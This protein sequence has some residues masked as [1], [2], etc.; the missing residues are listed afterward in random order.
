MLTVEI[1]EFFFRQAPNR[2][3]VE[4]YWK[5]VEEEKK[6]VEDARITKGTQGVGEIGNAL[7]CAG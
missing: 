7:Y 3:K 5:K 1:N 4:G 2:R 6:A